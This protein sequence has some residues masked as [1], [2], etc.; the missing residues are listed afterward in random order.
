[1]LTPSRR[2]LG[3]RGDVPARAKMDWNKI[4]SARSL[5]LSG[6]YSDPGICSMILDRCLI[7]ICRDAIGSFPEGSPGSQDEYES[8]CPLAR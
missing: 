6:F 2:R 8:A 7:A 5:I 4:I 3:Q 1:M